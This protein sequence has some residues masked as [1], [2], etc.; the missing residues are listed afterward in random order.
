[1]NKKS[2]FSQM[3]LAIIV[4]LICI[5]LTVVVALWVGNSNSDIFDLSELNWSNMIPV[6]VIGFFITGGAVGVILLFTAKE[7]FTKAREYLND[8]K[9]DGGKK[10]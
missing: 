1:M 4:S 3:M 6:F 5:V 9:K 7:L 8:I 2:V 10:E